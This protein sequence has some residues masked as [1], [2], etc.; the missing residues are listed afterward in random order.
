LSWINVAFV[1][2]VD[3]I[4]VHPI[5]LSSGQRHLISSRLSSN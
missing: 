3:G 5:S 1:E 2:R 4:A